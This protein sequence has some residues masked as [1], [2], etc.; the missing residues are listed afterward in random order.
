[1]TSLE[2]ALAARAIDDGHRDVD[3]P[4]V[5]AELKETARDHDEGAQPEQRHPDPQVREMQT[6]PSVLNVPLVLCVETCQTQLVVLKGIESL[7][8]TR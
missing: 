2:A 7:G 3:P 8:K 5:S 6:Y 4:Q 1:M